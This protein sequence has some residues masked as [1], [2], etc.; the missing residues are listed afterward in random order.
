MLLKPMTWGLDG[1]VGEE[2]RKE[3]KPNIARSFLFVF[4]EAWIAP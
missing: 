3:R 1:E 2:R 4:V